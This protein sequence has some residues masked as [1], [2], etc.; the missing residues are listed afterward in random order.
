MTEKEKLEKFDEEQEKVLTHIY[1]TIGKIHTLNK[2][3]EDERVEN[4]SNKLLERLD[5]FR[6]GAEQSINYIQL[7]PIK[8]GTDDIYAEIK[9]LYT[10]DRNS[11]SDIEDPL[12]KVM[13][14]LEEIKSEIKATKKSVRALLSRGTL[15]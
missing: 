10:I 12:R 5:I 14:I 7:N 11:E 13:V 9:D 2:T 4:E 1:D 6:R 3:N 15:E 8:R